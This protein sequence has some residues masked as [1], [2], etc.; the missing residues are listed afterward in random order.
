MGFVS[1]IIEFR[2]ILNRIPEYHHF[3][4]Q[5]CIILDR[6]VGSSDPEVLVDQVSDLSSTKKPILSFW[7][8]CSSRLHL[9]L[10]WV[11]WMILFSAKAIFASSTLKSGIRIPLTEREDFKSSTESTIST[12]LIHS[13]ASVKNCEQ[14]HT[15]VFESYLP[16]SKCCW[17]SEF[18]KMRI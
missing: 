11:L 14:V 18:V 7:A 5:V 10:K 3:C 13:I 4:K 15:S 17:R 8:F 6:I 1:S 16:T 12:P 9:L 2:P